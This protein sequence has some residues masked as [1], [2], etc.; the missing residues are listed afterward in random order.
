MDFANN[1]SA[2][3]LLSAPPSAI[4]DHGK[5]ELYGVPPSIAVE[6]AARYEAFTERQANDRPLAEQMDE[7]KK[8]SEGLEVAQGF[9]NIMEQNSQIPP[10]KKRGGTASWEAWASLPKTAPEE[11]LDSTHEYANNAHEIYS[12]ERASKLEHGK[13]RKDTAPLRIQKAAGSGI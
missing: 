6:A 7:V 5:D 10:R 13:A 3:L 4:P 11:E 9:D 8:A 1:D 12:K 2:K